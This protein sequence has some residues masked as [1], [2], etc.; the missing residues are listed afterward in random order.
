MRDA[1]LR[2]NRRQLLECHHSLGPA[3]SDKSRRKATRLG[4]RLSSSLLRLRELRPNLP[5][6]GV[7]SLCAGVGQLHSG[8]ASLF[9]NKTDDSAQHLD[10]LVS[11][12]SEIL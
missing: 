5:M 9:M 3:A 2:Q 7:C 8:Y 12:D 11:P 6:V 10:V 1:R 4:P